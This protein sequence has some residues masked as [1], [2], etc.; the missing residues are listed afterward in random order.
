MNHML[1][2]VIGNL[3]ERLISE[4]EAYRP[5]KT[6]R[7]PRRWLV[8]ACACLV[9]AVIALPFVWRE[10]DVNTVNL[11]GV[12]RNYQAYSA[13]SN[14]TALVWPW[15]YTMPEE[16]YLSAVYNGV[17]YQTT[18]RPISADLAAT[19]CG[20][21]TASGY[22]IYTETS[23]TQEVT[24]YAIGGVDTARLLA[25]DL[26]GTRFVFRAEQENNIPQTLGELLDWY[27][28][29]ADVR[30]DAFTLNGDTY[31]LTNDAPFRELLL[32]LRDA[33]LRTEETGTRE[34]MLSF[35]VTSEALGCYRR[36]F[37]ITTDG[38]VYTNILDYGYTFAVGT[39]AANTL[40]AAATAGAVKTDA[41]PYAYEVVGVVTVIEDG[42]FVVNDSVLCTDSSDGIAFR[43]PTDDLRIRR[44]LEIPHFAVGDSVRVSFAGKI[45][46][47]N[48]YTVTGAYAV[49]KVSLFVGDGDAYETS[50]GAD[51][52]VIM[53]SSAT[54]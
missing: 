25:L 28:L 23:Y 2:S 40:R 3:D 39:D 34:Q 36:V 10:P 52:I 11:G 32:G 19:P 5:R 42:Y 38:Y 21:A 50:D 1:L 6:A 12:V 24:V 44:Y 14:N 7:R 45:D 53:T 41:V 46:A 43:I 29:A 35:S 16:R 22:D 54:E 4:S 20:T 30:L 33:P 48:G 31:T 15:E 37:S 17:R 49:E 13:A 9:L 8:A 51:A 26:D 47:E 27:L 18:A